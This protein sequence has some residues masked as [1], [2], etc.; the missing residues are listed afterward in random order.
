MDTGSADAG[1]SAGARLDKQLEEANAQA[2]DIWRLAVRR[3][4]ATAIAHALVAFAT[5]V[6]GATLLGLGAWQLVTSD[7]LRPSALVL[8]IAGAIL[9]L[10][11]LRW[12][13]DHRRYETAM[14]G[15]GAAGASYTIFLFRLAMVRELVR[16]A[17]EQ[18]ADATQLRELDQLLQEIDQHTRS[19]LGGKPK[20]L[21]DLFNQLS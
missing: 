2:V 16:Q 11:A 9:L 12:G 5:A 21:D 14:L 6:G 13:L 10:G 20:S 17:A 19:A 3:A 4:R 15:I 18:P 8:S 7:D 1:S